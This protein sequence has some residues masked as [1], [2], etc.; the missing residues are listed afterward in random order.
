MTQ[1]ACRTDVERFCARLPALLGSERDG[2]NTVVVARAPGVVDV[3]GGLCEDGGGLVLQGALDVAVAAAAALRDD[4]QVVVCRL[5]YGD[6]P[7]EHAFPVSA[8]GKGASV[9]FGGAEGGD[10]LADYTILRA[11]VALLAEL[12][13][14]SGAAGLSRGVTIIFHSDWPDDAQLDLCGSLLASVVEATSEALSLRLDVVEKAMLCRSAARAAGLSFPSLRVPLG[15]LEA[16]S[17]GLLLVRTQ[18][19][20]SQT[21]QE[22]P[23]GVT[24]VA[25]DAQLGRPVTAQRQFETRLAAAMGHEII[26]EL[27]RQDG[28][29]VEVDASALSNVK[30]EDFVDRF[31]DRVPTRITGKAYAARYRTPPGFDGA[32]DPDRVHK[33]RSRAEHFIYEG[34]RV[35]EFTTMLARVRRTNETPLLASAGEL[36]YASHWSYSQRCGMGSVETDMIVSVLRNLG[37][38]AGFYGAKVTGFGSGGGMVVLMRDNPEC[39]AEL[40]RALEQVQAKTGRRIRAFRGAAPGAS[41]FGARRLDPAAVAGAS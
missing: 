32:I 21:V 30:P 35:Y 23:E 26:R 2:R 9:A 31:R 36:M 38:P 39:H 27:I 4:G 19:H 16:D 24:V 20:L 40:A 18:P 3:M 8:L 41:R 14:G 28:R 25:L 6:R 13:A 34:R 29:D 12:S 10:S 22:L 1:T 15:A 17:G 11:I 5:T 37:T 33:V 7:I